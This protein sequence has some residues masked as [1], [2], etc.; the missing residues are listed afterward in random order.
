MQEGRF[1]IRSYLKDTIIET[2]YRRNCNC[3]LAPQHVLG[4]L[5]RVMAGLSSAALKFVALFIDDI[6]SC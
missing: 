3:K 6:H 1:K 2:R 4:D 5:A